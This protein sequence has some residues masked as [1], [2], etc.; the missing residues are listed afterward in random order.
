MQPPSRVRKPSSRLIESQQATEGRKQRQRQKP[1]KQQPKKKQEGKKRKID[2]EASKQEGA[3][4]GGKKQKVD[5]EAA[6]VVPDSNFVAIEA[7]TDKKEISKGKRGAGRKRKA[8]GVTTSGVEGVLEEMVEEAVK[9]VEGKGEEE[10]IATAIE[11]GGGEGQQPKRKRARRGRKGKKGGRK[12]KKEAP[13]P[14]PT[15]KVPRPK[16]VRPWDSDDDLPPFTRPSGP[17]FEAV[18][19]EILK[20]FLGEE[21]RFHLSLLPEHNLN[22]REGVPAPP[23]NATKYDV[24]W[25]IDAIREDGHHEQ[26]YPAARTKIPNPPEMREEMEMIAAKEEQ[27]EADLNTIT[28]IRYRRRRGGYS[29][30][31]SV[32]V[33]QRLHSIETNLSMLREFRGEREEW[34]EERRRRAEDEDREEEERRVN[35]L[36]GLCGAG[37]SEAPMDT[38]KNPVPAPP[39][40]PKNRRRKATV[41]EEPVG[42]RR[43]TRRGGSGEG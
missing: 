23:T 37:G 22:A 18:P 25:L 6:V 35:L 21:E 8:E 11:G 40:V 19:M 32:T 26:E 10:E 20:D 29:L 14:A 7:G 34:W 27:L 16:R 15:K 42:K 3:K 38:R 24:A 2:E 36:R 41:F 5:E 33:G 31:L 13:P 39:P 12:A 17:A 43:R 28:E 9:E 1:G 4:R 30:T